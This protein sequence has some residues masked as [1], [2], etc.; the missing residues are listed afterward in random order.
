MLKPGIYVLFLLVCISWERGKI[1]HLYRLFWKVHT[2]TFEKKIILK[3]IKLCR[4]YLNSGAGTIGNRYFAIRIV[5][6]YALFWLTLF[7]IVAALL[8]RFW[9]IW[10]PLSYIGNALVATILMLFDFLGDFV[11]GAYYDYKV[12]KQ[13]KEQQKTSAKQS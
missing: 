8:S 13:K 6:A 12:Y 7:T 3:N 5:A 2:T 10:I 4:L 1:S 9:S 11:V